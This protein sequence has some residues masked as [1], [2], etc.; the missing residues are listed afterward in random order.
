MSDMKPVQS[1]VAAAAE[2]PVDEEMLLDHEYDG[3][4]EY[5]N[6]LPRWWVLIFWG[7]FIFA[8]GYF[9]WYTVLG[10]GKS[11]LEEY[12]EDVAQAQA[13][14]EKRAASEKVTEKGLEKLMQTPA[15]VKAGSAVFHSRC[16][17]CH[18]DHAQGIIGPNLTDSYWIHGNGTLMDIFNTV[19][20]GVPDK[21]MPTW[22]KQLKP[23]E[24][25]AVVAYVGTLR[26]TN[27][28]GKAPQGHEVKSKK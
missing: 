4:R 16:V 23:T 25:R 8:V 24:L 15:T 3:I 26:N 6:P 11:R 2:A 18:G 27:V 19:D 14:Q 1:K 13:L 21:G 22:G 5:D 10:K 20:K 17:P 28:K 12:R 9:L 7:S